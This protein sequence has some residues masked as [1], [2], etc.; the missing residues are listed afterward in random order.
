MG[1]FTTDGKSVNGTDDCSSL[2]VV[3]ARDERKERTG[4][5]SVCPCALFVVFALLAFFD[6]DTFDLHRWS[7]DIA[8]IARRDGHQHIQPFHDL[9]EDS[10]FVIQV[11]GGTVCNE[12]LGTVRTGS[13]IRHGEDALCVMPQTGMELIFKFVAWSA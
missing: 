1:V 2:L 6:G 9:A 8:R 3:P 13:R 5:F 11:R 4:D 12:K 10:M 7:V